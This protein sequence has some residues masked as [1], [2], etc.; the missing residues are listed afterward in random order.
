MGVVL[1]FFEEVVVEE[2]VDEVDV[3]EEHAATAE[4]RHAEF[5]QGLTL[6]LALL[7]L[8]HIGLPLVASHLATSEAPHRD[9][10]SLVC[11]HKIANHANRSFLIS[12]N[13]DELE[14]PKF[15]SSARSQC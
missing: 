10:H 5:V 15:R 12:T 9:D 4:P 8:R 1:S 3:S 2:F 14:V 13:C 11:N 7:Q 6:S